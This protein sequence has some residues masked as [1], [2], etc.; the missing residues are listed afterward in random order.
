MW[1]D[2]LKVKLKAIVP[3]SFTSFNG[4]L[5]TSGAAFQGNNC[6]DPGMGFGTAQPYGYDQLVAMYNK[7][8]VPAA[9][10]KLKMQ[11]YDTTATA[12]AALP[13]QMACLI[14]GYHDHVGTNDFT[15]WVANWS[16]LGNSYVKNAKVFYFQPD[17]PNMPGGRALRT[18]KYSLYCNWNKV[19]GEKR[20]GMDDARDIDNNTGP[21]YPCNFGVVFGTAA[22]S[23]VPSTTLMRGF[24]EITYYCVFSTPRTC[25]V[26]S[27]ATTSITTTG[28]AAQVQDETFNT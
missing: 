7:V 2:Q 12:T 15:S 26:S 25:P 10:L 17:T 4:I 23:A 16:N 5:I 11:I 13:P 9:K 22:A 1:P 3:A 18:R 19:L 14:L 8:R 6:F 21:D 27:S 28:N 24:I 20:A